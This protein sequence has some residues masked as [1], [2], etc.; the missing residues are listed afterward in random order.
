VK[1]PYCGKKAE[2]VDNEKIY[3]RRYGKSYMAWWCPKCDARV[4]THNNTRKPLGTMANQELRVMRIHAHKLI[5][6]PWRY[7]NKT[8]KQVYKELKEKYGREIHIGECNKEMCLKI[9]DD[10]SNQ[11]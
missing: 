8:R 5:D 4:G 9:I 11:V 1:C 3:G 10:I 7:G 2:F 6:K